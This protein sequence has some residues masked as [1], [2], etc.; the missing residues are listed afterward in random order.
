MC[1]PLSYSYNTRRHGQAFLITSYVL[2]SLVL[3]IFLN[4]PRILEISPIG[5]RLDKN[6]HYLRF[7]MYYQ[8]T[9]YYELN[10]GAPIISNLLD[11]SSSSD[12]W[13]Y[14]IGAFNFSQLQDLHKDPN[15][16]H[17]LNS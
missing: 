8:V 2:P 15:S 1:F 12:N 9:W 11:L 4:I 16:S 7:Y 5:V 13:A 6:K 3:A 14:S 17:K 10:M